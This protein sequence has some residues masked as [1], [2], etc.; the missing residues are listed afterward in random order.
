VAR[1]PDTGFWL[2]GRE[3]FKT[4]GH[5]HSQ[6][7]DTASTISVDHIRTLSKE[8]RDAD[9]MVLRLG[10]GH[11]SD[12]ARGQTGFALVRHDRAHFRYCC[13]RKRLVCT[14]ANHAFQ[15]ACV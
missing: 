14:V 10:T 8:L 11:G 6:G 9:T 13:G 4:Y 1:Q 2:C 3:I 15:L 5:R 7:A 12:D